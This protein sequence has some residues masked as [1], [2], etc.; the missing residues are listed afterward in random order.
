MKNALLLSLCLLFGLGCQNTESVEAEKPFS[1]ERVVSPVIYNGDTGILNIDMVNYGS[2]K[3]KAQ[4]QLTSLNSPSTQTY[5]I[6]SSA[7]MNDRI[8]FHMNAIWPIVPGRYSLLVK[9][10]DG[11]IAQTD[12]ILE[13]R[14]GQPQLD[15]FTLRITPSV[16][17]QPVTVKGQNLFT[18]S[19]FTLRLRSLDGSSSVI[20]ATNY[21]VNGAGIT[22]MPK[23]NLTPGYHSLRL[24]N[25][26]TF[27]QTCYRFSVIRSARH[28]YIMG[29]EDYAGPYSKGADDFCPENGVVGI[30]RSYFKVP[31]GHMITFGL[32]HSTPM[33]AG[34]AF[35][36]GFL[37]VVKFVGVADGQ[38]FRS[39]IPH[40]DYTGMT[41]N[42]F[43][44]YYRFDAAMPAGQYRL[45]VELTE[46]ETG[47]SFES[48]PFEKTIS[49][50]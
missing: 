47:A 27:T 40:Y 33:S 24:E 2:D 15:R 12:E 49:L 45:S 48:E 35:P 3:A 42:Y 34:G 30:A 38:V 14:A 23:T 11:Q 36:I 4:L 20:P 7:V 50:Q 9:R 29:I 28:P 41:T 21:G 26:N 43:Q 32:G 44:A 5:T 18:D 37:A 6:G 13:V 22:L 1:I 46:K 16:L 10:A 19:K 17:G 31:Y 25:D 8:Y 39:P